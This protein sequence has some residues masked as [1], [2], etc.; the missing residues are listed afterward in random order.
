MAW[1]MRAGL[2]SRRSLGIVGRVAVVWAT[3]LLVTLLGSIGF[4]GSDALAQSLPGGASSIQE[5]Y[6][7]WQVRCVSGEEN[8]SCVL[9]QRQ[10]SQDTG[11][12]LLA[13]EFRTTEA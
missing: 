2:S 12:L 7:D 3:S 13:L 1:F 9:T 8:A 5:T 6:Q 4:Y 11:Q 10:V